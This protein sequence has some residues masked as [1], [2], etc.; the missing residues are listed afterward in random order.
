MSKKCL[1]VIDYQVD[2]VTGSLGFN[3]ARQL[4][5]KLEV[6]INKKRLES[7]DIIYT[8]DTHFK[9]T[10]FDTIEAKNLPILHTVKGTPGFELYGKI[11]KTRKKE[12]VIFEKETFGSIEL[13]KYILDNNYLEIEIVGVV[14]NICVLSNATIIRSFCKNALISVLKDYCASNDLLL[15]EKALDVLK[16]ISVNVI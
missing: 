3:E 13:G 14:T 5:D 9:D 4:E 1:I 6:L 12:D 16:S 11:K 15:H 7:Y 10:Y 8:Y 2:F